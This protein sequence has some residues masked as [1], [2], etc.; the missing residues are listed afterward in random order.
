MPSAGRISTPGTLGYQI[1]YYRVIP[2]A[3]GHQIRF[4]TD[5]LLA[6]GELYRG[7]RTLG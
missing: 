7:T 6:F 1:A 4:V 3:T 2:T 5:R